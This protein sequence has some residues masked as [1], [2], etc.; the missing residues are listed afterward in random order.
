M[1][2]IEKF[3]WSLKSWVKCI[4]HRESNSLLKHLYENVFLN[5]LVLT[6]YLNA[7]SE[8][9]TL[10]NISIKKKI[11]RDLLL[12]WSKLANKTVISIYHNEII[13]NN[14]NIRVEENTIFYKEWFQS[15]I[16][17]IKDIHDQQNQRYYFS[18]N[19][20]RRPIYQL[21]SF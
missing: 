18:I 6:F 3:I 12:A 19:C 8:R 10:L 2:D 11:L 17:H 4:L 9:L 15:G 13:W 20:K 5:N 1:I 16:K 7:I 14:T 21:P